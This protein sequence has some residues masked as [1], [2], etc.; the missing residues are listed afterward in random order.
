MNLSSTVYLDSALWANDSHRMVKREVVLR[1]KLDCIL[2]LHSLPFHPH[3]L[4]K[5]TSV[6]SHQK[7]NFY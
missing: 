5:M 7:C 6:A 1:T 2:S 3:Y 4:E